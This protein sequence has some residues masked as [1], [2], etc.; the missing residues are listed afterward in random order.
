MIIIAQLLLVVWFFGCIKTYKIKNRKL[1]D[2]MG[3]KSAEFGMFCFYTVGII[4]YHLF[5]VVGKWFLLVVL[6][7]WNVIQFF[8]HWYYTIFG[9]SPKKLAGYNS[10]F[11]DTVR[12]IPMSE[13]RLIPDFYHIVLHTLLVINLVWLIVKF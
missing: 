1:V 2:G 5:N 8:C 11:K 13:T 7:A 6:V 4:L 10:C 3:I 9:A 12:I